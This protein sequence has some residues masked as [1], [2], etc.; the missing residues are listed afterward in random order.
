M[1]VARRWA[2][3]L[4]A[5]VVVWVL[6]PEERGA[7]LGLSGSPEPIASIDERRALLRG[8]LLL[9]C[10]FFLLLGCRVIPVHLSVFLFF[11]CID[12]SVRFMKC[13]S[14]SNYNQQCEYNTC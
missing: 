11:T 1:L 4:C 8:L 13:T 14:F 9:Y 5:R 12:L 10:A 2:K 7:G 3:P 6:G